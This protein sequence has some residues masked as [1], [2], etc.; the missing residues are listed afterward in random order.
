MT[1]SPTR[2]YA[3]WVSLAL[4][5]ALLVTVVIFVSHHGEEMAFARLVFHARPAWLLFG[6]LFQAG[7]YAADAR[8]WQQVLRRANVAKPLRSYVGLGLA[9]PFI[10]PGYPQRRPERHLAHSPWTGPTGRAARW[11]Y[12]SRSH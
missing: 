1:N 9:K 8:I 6:L 11:H 7:T 4:G 3:R 10:G 5:L 2:G 12:G